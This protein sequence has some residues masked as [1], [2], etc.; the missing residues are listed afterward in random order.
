MHYKTLVSQN[1][2]RPNLTKFKLSEGGGRWGVA[3][4][5]D[6]R[7]VLDA[8]ASLIE[9]ERPDLALV[10]IEQELSSQT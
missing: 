8:I 2:C 7:S 10:L 3:Q 5:C 6:C 4:G 1:P 9:A